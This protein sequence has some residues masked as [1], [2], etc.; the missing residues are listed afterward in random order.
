VLVVLP[1]THERLVVKLELQLAQVVQQVL[2]LAQVV[3]QELLLVV[4]PLELVE[5][6]CLVQR[7][8]LE[9][10]AYLF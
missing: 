10:L 6:L 9:H 5:R 7:F 8:P 3:Q 4:A 2:Q 1:L